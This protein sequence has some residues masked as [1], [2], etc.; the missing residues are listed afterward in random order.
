MSLSSALNVA[1]TGL[2]TSTTLLQLAANNISNAQT[3]GYTEKSAALSSSALGSAASGV[4]IV[5]YSRATDT[6]LTQ[7]YN[8]ATSTGSYLSTQNSYMQQVQSILDSTANNPAL[9]NAVSQFAAAWTQ[10]QASPEDP[11]V[12]QAV[13]QAGNNFATQVNAVSSQVTSLAGASANRYRRPR[14]YATQ[15]R[16]QS[17]RQ[18]QSANFCRHRRKPTNRQSGRST[19]CTDQSDFKHHQSIRVCAQSGTNRALYAGWPRFTGQQHTADF[20]L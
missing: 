4:E 10:L 16:S 17:G 3:P 9:S 12:Q 6:V 14:R 5:N 1:L 2:Q 11:T 7:S 18:P 19:R 8:A 15:Y 13:V 20:F